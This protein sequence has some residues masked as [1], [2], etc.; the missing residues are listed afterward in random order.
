MDRW[1]DFAFELEEPLIT[2]FDD[3]WEDQEIDW[4]KDPDYQK[5]L[6]DFVAEHGTHPF[7]DEDL[8]IWHDGRI[9]GPTV[10]SPKE[11]Q[12]E[13][14]TSDSGC[15]DGSSES[16]ETNTEASSSGYDGDSSSDDLKNDEKPVSTNDND[17][18]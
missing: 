7:P 13:D 4:S 1:D 14:H 17:S 11:G 3:E 8:V 15:L 10:P 18:K 5:W 6:D 2:P 9:L 12:L 16:S